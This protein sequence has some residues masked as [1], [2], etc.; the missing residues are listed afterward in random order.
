MD[1]ALYGYSRRL[2]T[3]ICAFAEGKN[4]SWLPEVLY[5]ID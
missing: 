4:S 5:Y 2:F 1:I 3:E